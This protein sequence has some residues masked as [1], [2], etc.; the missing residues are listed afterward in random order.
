M[1]ARRRR[2]DRASARTR[3]AGSSCRS[4]T[5]QAGPEGLRLLRQPGLVH[6]EAGRGGRLQRLLLRRRAGRRH[7]EGLGVR[8]C[9]LAGRPEGS[10][11]RRAAGHDELRRD[12]RRDPARPG[13]RGLRQE[14]RR[15][16]GAEERADRRDRRRLPDLPLRH[17]RPGS[18]RGR[19]SGGSRP[20]RST[21]GSSSRRG[22][23]CETASTRRSPCSRRTGRSSSSRRSGSTRP[24][25]PSS[26]SARLRGSGASG[27]RSTL[28]ALASTI[29][30]A[31]VVVF[32]VSN[33]AR[34]GRRSS[35]CSSTARSSGNRSR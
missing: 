31:V 28:I 23:R 12:R 24:L 16:H 19:S 32:V 6:T 27:R 22:T 13:S 18:R 1:T 34:A 35:G 21:S 5:L 4:T 33:G 9:H 30:F 20:A 15:D 3:F 2:A 26:S 14:H 10:E 29:V 11:A 7:A 17:G 8:G 25:H